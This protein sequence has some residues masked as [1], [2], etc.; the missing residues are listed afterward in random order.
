[1]GCG[2]QA[3]RYLLLLQLSL[4]PTGHI[5]KEARGAGFDNVHDYLVHQQTGNASSHPYTPPL[6][7][8]QRVQKSGYMDF[9][10]GLAM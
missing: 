8:F 4:L 10:A 6:G 1:M 2:T 3:K 5:I 7:L 9:I